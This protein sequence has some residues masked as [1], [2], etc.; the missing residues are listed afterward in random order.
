MLLFHSLDTVRAA[1]HAI[2]YATIYVRDTVLCKDNAALFCTG[3]L[4]AR[5]KRPGF[6]S[7]LY[8]T[9]S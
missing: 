5:N 2:H 8:H 7:L 9:P 3:N 6:F 4:L 1:V